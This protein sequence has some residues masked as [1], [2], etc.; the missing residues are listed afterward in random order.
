MKLIWRAICRR[1]PELPRARVVLSTATSIRR[2]ATQRP[3]EE[4][5]RVLLRL[6]S[7]RDAPALL[8]PPLKPGGRLHTHRGV[9]SHDNIIGKHAR[10]T[11]WTEPVRSGRAGQEYRIF[12]VS[13]ADY[14]RLTGR[15]VTPIYSA[16]A[17]LIVSL[18]DLHPDVFD[19]RCFPDTDEGTQGPPRLEVLEAGTGHGSL[20]LHLSRAVHGANPPRPWEHEPTDDKEHAIEQW[21][22][23]RRAVIHTVDVSARYSAHAESV[24]AG[25]RRGMYR[26]NVDFAVGAVGDWVLRT[27]ADRGGKPFLS[28]AILDMPNAD[29][30]LAVVASALQTDGTL[31]VFNP[32]ITQITQC[33][34][35]IRN[36]FLPLQL[37]TVI[38]LG[39]NGLSGGREWD[40]RPVRPRATRPNVKHRTASGA[41]QA[42]ASENTLHDEDVSS[43]ETADVKATAE[44]EETEQ[45][46][47]RQEDRST[48]QD[49]L[50]MVCRPK[51]GERVI[52]GGFL[53]VWKKMASAPLAVED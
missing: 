26:H 5:D 22:K 31:V 6:K 21:K 16:D 15:L 33:T 29:W 35:T 37:E 1:R 53:G 18:L 47:S 42:V 13:L 27:Q 48:K 10:S 20:T 8:T 41:A 30:N 25:F 46:E 23:R 9:L 4:D 50:S 40:V 11:V 28:H 43:D 36:E 45:L 39:V 19:S 2:I 51:V 38:E 24:V 44:S 3:F 49:G 32:S 7:D 34:T 17:N 12:D 14:V 52:G